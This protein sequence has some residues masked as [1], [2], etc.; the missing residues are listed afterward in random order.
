MTCHVCKSDSRLRWDSSAS[1]LSNY[2][3]ELAQSDDRVIVA[4]MEFSCRGECRVRRCTGC[5]PRCALMLGCQLRSDCLR[6][7]RGV[8]RVRC[9][10]TSLARSRFSARER[11]G[12]R[13]ESLSS[14]R[15]SPVA[16]GP[17]IPVRSGLVWSRLVFRSG[18]SAVT[19][20]LAI[21]HPRAG[22]RDAS[23]LADGYV[24][25]CS[26]AKKEV[27]LESLSVICS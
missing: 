27:N 25:A 19:V 8:L 14:G 9:H 4:S 26:T 11:G 20:S 3:R 22:R 5:A 18:L 7:I 6:P 2:Y 13:P 16:E 21:A 23:L 1:T 12:Y 24:V 10:R 15:S 17:E